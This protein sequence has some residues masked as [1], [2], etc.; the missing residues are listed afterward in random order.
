M[1]ILVCFVVNK[2]SFHME[3]FARGVTLKQR[4]KAAWKWL[5]QC[6]WTNN[7]VFEQLTQ[8][9]PQSVC[10]L[11]LLSNKQERKG[12]IDCQYKVLHVVTL[13]TTYQLGKCAD[14][15]PFKYFIFLELVVCAWR[16][17][18]SNFKDLPGWPI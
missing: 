13:L 9:R 14:F 1:E 3:V 12:I 2:T 17:N 18:F 5:Q 10:N 11:A 16:R 6:L 4:W 8:L 15:H 7:S